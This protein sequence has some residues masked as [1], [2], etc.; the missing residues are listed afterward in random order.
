MTIL[1]Q[2]AHDTRIRVEED[3][4]RLPPEAL[5]DTFP[6]SGGAQAFYGAVAR[7]GLSLICEVKKAS[8]SK[9]IIDEE[10]DYLTIARSYA[11]AGAD[12]ISCL[13]EPKWFLGSDRIFTD[14]RSVVTTPMLR[15][16]FVVDEY[17]ILQA[18]AMGADAVLLICALHTTARLEHFLTLCAD[19]GLAALTEAHDEKEIASAVSAGAKMIGVNNRNLKDFTVDLDNAARLRS[20]IPPGC[21]YVSESGVKTPEDAIMMK[22]IGADAVLMGEALMRAPDRAEAVRNFKEAVQ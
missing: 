17:Q 12:C 11:S 5:S 21:L 4:K 18:R 13:T 1:D 22:K 9:G 3:K 19:L 7:P 8:P 15:K 10:F 6:P 14:I 16:D 2:I 20:L